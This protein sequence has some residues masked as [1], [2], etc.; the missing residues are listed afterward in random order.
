M[1]ND[2]TEVEEAEEPE[3]EEVI[4]EQIEEE[5]DFATLAEQAGRKLAKDI[6]EAQREI[7]EASQL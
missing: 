2:G 7:E 1:N 6:E 4:E 5:S 3:Q